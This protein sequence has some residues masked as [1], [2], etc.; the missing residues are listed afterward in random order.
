MTL[1]TSDA[2]AN[3][4]LDVVESTIGTAPSLTVRSGAMPANCAAADAG[5]VGATMALPSD[6]MNAAGSRSKT[7]LGTW[8]D[9]S[10]DASILARHFRI[11]QGATCHMQGLVSEPWAINKAYQLNQQV[12]NGGNIYICTTAGTSAGSGGPTGTGSGITDNTA[13]WNYVQTGV[14]MALDNTVINAA[15]LVSITTFTLSA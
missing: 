3:A 5:T 9:P 4:Q 11:K 15:Q 1:Q 13:V 8:S 14:D 6:Y 10:A 7:L 2:I 12:H